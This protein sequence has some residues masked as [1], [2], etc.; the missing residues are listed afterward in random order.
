MRWLDM[1]RSIVLL[2]G[3]SLVGCA[4]DPT[5][6]QT[7]SRLPLWLDGTGRAAF[8]VVVERGQSLDSI[9]RIYRV[10]KR[11]II[12]TNHLTAQYNL[13]PGMS[14]EVPLDKRLRKS[15][16]WSTSV[17]VAVM[18]APAQRK[19]AKVSAAK[20]HARAKHPETMMVTSLPRSKPQ[21]NVPQ[22]RPS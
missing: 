14:L 18:K 5:P 17:T 6:N 9:A 11:D 12:A 16:A 19:V 8:F 21:E 20:R 3:L 2:S 15:P 13:K 22:K 4:S 10:A 1:L 7:Q